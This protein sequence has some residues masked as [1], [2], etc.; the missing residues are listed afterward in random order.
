[1]ITDTELERL[2]RRALLIRARND[3][4][5]TALVDPDHIDPDGVKDWPIILIEAPRMLP[6]RMACARGSDIAMDVHAFAGPTSDG[7][8]TGRR[9]ISAIGNQIQTTFAPN[10]LT[11]EDGAQCRLAFSDVRILKDADPDHFHWFGQLNCQVLK[12]V[13]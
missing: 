4:A 9:H 13:A 7:T 5:L 1:M 3:A 12:A 8:M 10:V 2:T 11:L 6:R